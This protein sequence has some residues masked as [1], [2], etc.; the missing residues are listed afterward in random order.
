MTQIPDDQPTV[1]LLGQNGN[2]FNVLGRCQRAAQKAGWTPEQ[3]QAF[4]E[5]AMRGD[6][7]HLI[8]TAMKYFDV[9]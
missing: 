4:R 5:E 3:I 7:D 9:Q 8:G 1:E 6:Y 2:A